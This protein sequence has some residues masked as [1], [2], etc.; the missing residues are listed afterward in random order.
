MKRGGSRLVDFP[1]RLD[2]ERSVEQRQWLIVSGKCGG[3]CEALTIQSDH[4]DYMIQNLELSAI[5]GIGG[6]V[7][8]SNRHR[9]IR[10]D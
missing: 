10:T 6:F 3:S 4:A 9:D 5:R 2:D 8:V 7:S 1:T